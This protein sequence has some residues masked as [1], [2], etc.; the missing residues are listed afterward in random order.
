MDRAEMLEGKRI[1][2]VDDERDVL[3]FISEALDMC[4]VDLAS[5][6]E[7]AVDF[8][9]RYLYHVAIFDIMGVRGYDLLDIA[10]SKDIPAL[11]LTAHALSK[12]SLKKSV[13]KGA[14]YYVPKDKMYHIADFLVDILEANEKNKNVWVKWYERMSRFC[15]RRFGPGWREDEP[16]FWDVYLQR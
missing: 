10:R 16:E 9:D 11:M 13:E 1:L 12:D 14:S 6:Y 5:T 2:V 8:L 15:D 7:E 3:D 4:T